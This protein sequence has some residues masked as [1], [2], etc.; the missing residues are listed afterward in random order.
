V[1]FNGKQEDYHDLCQTPTPSPHWTCANYL[2]FLQKHPDLHSHLSPIGHGCMALWTGLPSITISL[3]NVNDCWWCG[4]K[5]WHFDWQWLG[6]WYWRCRWQWIHQDPKS[7]L[8]NEEDDSYDSTVERCVIRH[9]RPG[10]C[11]NLLLICF[12]LKHYVYLSQSS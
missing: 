1:E 10:A 5:H 7:L 6:R 4:R 2:S 11:T 9:R 3:Y 8:T 12:R